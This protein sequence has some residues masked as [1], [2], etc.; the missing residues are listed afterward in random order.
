MHRNHSTVPGA[1]RA[2]ET[3]CRDPDSPY[4]ERFADYVAREL[5]V[6]PEN[7]VVIRNWTHLPPSPPID[8]EAA[9]K[10]RGWAPGDTMVLHAG[11]MGAKQGLD[12]V[13]DAARL[14]DAQ[15]APVRFVLLGD[16]GERDRLRELAGGIERIEFIDPLGTEEFRAALAAADVLLVNE[17]PGV[18]EMAVPS[19]LTSYFD[20]GRPVVAAINVAGITAS[21]LAAADAGIVVPAGEPDQ[22]IDAVL[23]LRADPALAAQFG[24]AGRRYRETVLDQDAATARWAALIEDLAGPR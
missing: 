4:H 17:K 7:I 24:A 8:R 14:A 16:G 18:A 13:V 3:Y 19:K 11:N 12:N 15:L 21:E 9:R 22:L 6:A 5:G 20:A 1:T 10:A 23:R 2:P